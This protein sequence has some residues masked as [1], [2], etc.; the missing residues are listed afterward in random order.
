MSK[1][2]S[3]VKR[4]LKSGLTGVD[5]MFVERKMQD[6]FFVVQIVWMKLSGSRQ[7]TTLPSPCI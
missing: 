5:K 2:P 4:E 6:K 1:L 3:T 7:V